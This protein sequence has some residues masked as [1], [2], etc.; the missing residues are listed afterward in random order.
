[1]LAR[2]DLA[3]GMHEATADD[4]AAIAETWLTYF[5]R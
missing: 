3:P 5:N 4:R 2:S 1:M